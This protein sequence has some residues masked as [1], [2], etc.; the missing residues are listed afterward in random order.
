MPSLIRFIVF[1]AIVAGLAYGGMFALVHFVKP[2]DREISVR[3]PTDK[4]APPQNVTDG[5][6][7][8]Q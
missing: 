6:Q 4:L 5:Q 7:A 8:Q 1:C 3:V 2:K